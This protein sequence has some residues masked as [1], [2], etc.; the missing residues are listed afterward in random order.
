MIVPDLCEQWFMCV[1]KKLPTSL[2]H[3]SGAAPRCV[4]DSDGCSGDPGTGELGLRDRGHGTKVVI[5]RSHGGG[6][7]PREPGRCTGMFRS[8]F[9]NIFGMLYLGKLFSA[10]Y[11][12]A[13]LSFLLSVPL[14]IF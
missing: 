10:F 5:R 14:G 4:G 8:I 2:C 11:F 7:S 1:Y 9:R 13:D 6:S 12:F 3:L